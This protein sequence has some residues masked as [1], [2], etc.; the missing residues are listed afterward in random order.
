MERHFGTYADG[1]GNISVLYVAPEFSS[2]QVGL[3]G[4]FKD[5]AASPRV[6]GFFNS[7][8][9]M[10]I[11]RMPSALQ[12]IEES[13][14]EGGNFTHVYLSGQV[15][16]IQAKAFAGCEKLVYIEIPASVT[17]IDDSAFQGSPN[18]TIGCTA[19][20]EAYNYAV[21]LGINWRLLDE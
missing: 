10:N 5:S 20:S 21:R 11:M 19:G 13:A 12:Q 6:I 18:V 2:C 9:A 15:H 8:T 17:F 7:D 4:T 3:G 16:S 1:S 14:F